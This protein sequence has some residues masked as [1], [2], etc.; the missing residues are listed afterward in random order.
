LL[1]SNINKL[2]PFGTALLSIAICYDCEGDVCAIVLTG[3]QDLP[4]K[5]SVAK[6]LIEKVIKVIIKGNYDRTSLYCVLHKVRL[7]FFLFGLFILVYI[8]SQFT[9]LSDLLRN[10][11]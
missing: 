4:T 9:M 7:R 5:E 6:L 10:N 3:C 2:S 11:I 8:L 1:N